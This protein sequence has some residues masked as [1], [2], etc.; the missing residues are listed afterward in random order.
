MKIALLFLASVFV[1]IALSI[2]RERRR[3]RWRTEFVRKTDVSA[4]ISKT[5]EASSVD[6]PVIRDIKRVGD[7]HVHT[8]YDPVTCE[9]VVVLRYES[10]CTFTQSD[11]AVLTACREHFRAPTLPQALQLALAATP[12]IIRDRDSFKDRWH[13]YFNKWDEETLERHTAEWR[14][15]RDKK[16][17][18]E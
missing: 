4:V 14:A 15:K 2:I 1:F 9:S 12:G 8:G 3:E 16:T 17:E 18:G 6:F 7:F 5:P 13:G 10:W 11:E